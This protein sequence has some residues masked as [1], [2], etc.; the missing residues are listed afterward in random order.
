MGIYDRGNRV[1]SQVGA[2]V[3][4]NWYKHSQIHYMN[5]MFE[6]H[7]Y[8]VY[9]REGKLSKKKDQVILILLEIEN[10]ENFPGSSVLLPPVMF[11]A[12]F[13]KLHKGVS[14]SCPKVYIL[15]RY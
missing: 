15:N 11:S 13:L 6:N 10:F 2:I 12:F 7:Q 3:N 8:F 4:A 1:A 14:T 9:T 5:G